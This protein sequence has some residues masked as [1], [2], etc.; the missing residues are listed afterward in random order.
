M[1][2]TTQR[3]AVVLG[4]LVYVLSLRSLD[5]VALT[6]S[7]PVGQALR[8]LEELQ[9]GVS[10][11]AAKQEEAYTKYRSWCQSETSE[12][13]RQGEAARKA[14]IQLEA[15][16]YEASTSV[17]ASAAAI[18]RLASEKAR[19][20]AKLKSLQDV[21]GQEEID[22]NASARAL[23]DAISILDRADE[24][25][26]GELE[27]EQDYKASLHMGEGT[28]EELPSGA[29]AYAGARFEPAPMP[30]MPSPLLM[31]QA[32]PEAAGRI[33]E[34]F[35]GLASLVDSAGLPF[36]NRTQLAVLLQGRVQDSERGK[37]N[38]PSDFL[39][40][41]EEKFQRRFSPAPPT[42]TGF[43]KDVLEEYKQREAAKVSKY[44]PM[45]AD[46]VDLVKKMRG[47]A[48]KSLQAAR[49]HENEARTIF[50]ALS[51]SLEQQMA[52]SDRNMAVE[53]KSKS[54]QEA[55]KLTREGYQAGER[56]EMEAVNSTL[57]AATAACMQAS[58]NE[59]KARSGRK[60]L[61]PLLEEVLHEL[62]SSGTIA[63]SQASVDQP[64]S[65][66]QLFSGAAASMMSGVSQNFQEA[67][68][69]DE[70]DEPS[71]PRA[72]DMVIKALR[73]LAKQQSSSVFA[74]LASRIED[75]RS[76]KPAEMSKTYAAASIAVPKN[77]PFD[78]ARKLMEDMIAKLQ[79]QAD[80]EREADA[81]CKKEISRSRE[82]IKLLDTTIRTSH[83]DIDLANAESVMLKY[84]VGRTQEELARLTENEASM[85][86]ARD[87]F[88][89]GS[90]QEKEHLQRGSE[91]VQL[92]IDRLQDYFGEAVGGGSAALIRGHTDR[93]S[94]AVGLMAASMGIGDIDLQGPEQ[95]ATS[96]QQQQPVV[97]AGQG[98][99][100]FLQTLETLL[101]QSMDR[102]DSR[103]Y[104]QEV[105]YQDAFV[106]HQALANLKQKRLDGKSKRA[107]DLDLEVRK[108]NADLESAKEELTPLIQYHQ[109]MKEKCSKRETREDRILRRNQELEGLKEAMSVL[110]G[111][112]SLVQQMKNSAPP[113]SFLQRRSVGLPG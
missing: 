88:Q 46:F 18:E 77:H 103:A 75:V 12:L 56:S 24:V 6:S 31:Q 96:E 98:L 8:V 83:I 21:R 32:N 28:V 73:R 40:V 90:K 74:Q 85:T 92:S 81:F 4:L 76:Q 93:S 84:D 2:Q 105:Q 82:R 53:K 39:P 65:L 20:E 72:G 111:E 25:L 27:K 10:G 52:A 41:V 45:T 55:L 7:N 68:A 60:Q 102:L 106:K 57:S 38:P 66:L 71:I 49:S 17:Q 42:A 99:S 3:T 48:H 9:A 91:G 59:E 79:A 109:Q 78:F 61:L 43:A 29:G 14:S 5:A 104:E 97:A 112:V 80:A 16:I 110:E 86:G 67:A 62:R 22:F 58:L 51:S 44:G 101:A 69:G 87:L 36:Q 11:A 30:Q 64:P 100:Q 19:D 34:V 54:A 1:A 23:E 50:Q 70:D 94:Q 35:K 37:V 47:E 33:A 113:S 26:S 63:A 15:G 89:A 108:L 95:A 107:K 13:R